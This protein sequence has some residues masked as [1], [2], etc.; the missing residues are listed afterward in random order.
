MHLTRR[1]LNRGIIKNIL[2]IILVV[3]EV[4]ILVVFNNKCDKLKNTNIELESMIQNQSNTIEDLN[5]QDNDLNNRVLQLEENNSQLTEE[6]TKLLEDKANLEWEIS[7]LKTEPQIMPQ[8]NYKD[9][10]SYMSYTAITNRSSRQW[11]LQQQAATNENGFRCIDGR[12]LVAVGTGWGL[13]V[14]DRA[15]VYCDG[16]NSFEVI[17]G[18]IKADIHTLSDNKTTA[19][20]NCRCEFIVDMG[21][22]NKTVKSRGNVSALQEYSGYVVDIK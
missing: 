7:S 6:K 21:G 14:G 22:L 13:S 19:S 1:C 4:T 9:F 12:P 8:I 20:N 10:K 2:I 18:D 16:G 5:T 17:I 15:V 3:F 11:A